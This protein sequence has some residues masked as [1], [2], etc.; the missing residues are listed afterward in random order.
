MAQRQKPSASRIFLENMNLNNQ[1]VPSIIEED[2]RDIAITI[3]IVEAHLYHA[4]FYH[5]IYD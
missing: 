2:N 1:E 3:F 5:D 4:Y